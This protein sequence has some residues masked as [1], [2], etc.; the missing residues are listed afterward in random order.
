MCELSGKLIAWLDR[1]LSVEETA[2]VE[3]HLA[4][5][6]ECRSGV[7]AYKR[8]SGE[9]DAYCDATVASNVPRE[10]PRWTPVAIAAG[11]LAA[12]VALLLAMP[13]ARVEA[14]VSHSSQVAMAAS[15]AAAAAA[16]PA[17]IRP[18]MPRVH[19]RPAAPTVSVRN[20]DSSPLQNQN[21]YFLPDGPMIQIAIPADEMFPPG[22]V[23][24]G[25]HFVADLTIAADG[26]AE[27]LSLRPRLASYERRTTHP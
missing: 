21:S 6:S 10:A 8:V 23:P 18:T 22:A 19:R 7:D 26:S 14:P 2:E 12:F 15:P 25:I 11:A 4:G 5:C 27:R 1:E 20:Q 13:R 3:R 17:A 16:V 24:E 9:F